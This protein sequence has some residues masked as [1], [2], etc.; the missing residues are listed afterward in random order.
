MTEENLQKAQNYRMSLSPE[1]ISKKIYKIY[2][3][4]GKIFFKIKK[5]RFMLPG[6]GAGFASG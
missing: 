1:K 4:C 3:S 2:V 5:S 6:A